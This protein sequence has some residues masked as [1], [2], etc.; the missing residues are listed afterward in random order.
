MSHHSLHVLSLLEF[1]VFVDAFLDEDA[2][3]RGEVKLLVHLAEFNLQLAAQQL[4]G[5]VGAVAQDCAHV[6]ELRFVVLDHAAVGRDRH[7]AVGE[8]IERVHGLVG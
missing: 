4:A 5:A 1:G 7:L 6:Q 3:Q 8:R 2:F